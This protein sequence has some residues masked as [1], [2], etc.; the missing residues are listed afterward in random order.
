M[1]NFGVKGVFD[2]Q[3]LDDRLDNPI[4]VG[5]VLQVVLVITHRHKTGSTFTVKS[6]GTGF[7]YLFQPHASYLIAISSS[8]RRYDIEQEAGD[9][10]VSEMRGNCRSH[11]SC[12]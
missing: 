3:S 6:R 7:E 4:D 5:Q 10:D 9:S 1:L 11:H 8:I 12:A 2:V